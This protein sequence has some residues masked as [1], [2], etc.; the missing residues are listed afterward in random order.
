MRMT[1]RWI[2]YVVNK[3]KLVANVLTSLLYPVVVFFQHSGV[4]ECLVMAGPTKLRVVKQGVWG[5]QP[6][7]S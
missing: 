6:P 7:K 1:N 4:T 5:A 3:G 2:K